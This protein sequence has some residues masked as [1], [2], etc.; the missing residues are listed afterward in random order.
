[1]AIKCT[2][3]QGRKM[4]YQVEISNRFAAL[5]NLD[6]DVDNRP[7]EIIREYKTFSQ[8]ADYYEMKKHE[9]WFDKGC[10]KLSDQRKQAKLQWLQYPGKING[11]NLS[12]IRCEAIRYFRN[13]K[14]EYMKD[15]MSLQLTIRTRILETCIEE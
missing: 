6:H 10:S 9:P 13:K 8:R 14:G 11:A 4:Q 3:Y 2:R 7:W 5:E 1:M 15:R 12:N